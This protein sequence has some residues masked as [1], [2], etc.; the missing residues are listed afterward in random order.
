MGRNGPAR[1]A[2][3]PKKQNHRAGLMGRNGPARIALTPKKQ[4]GEH[5]GAML[6]VAC[7]RFRG[8]GDDPG[9]EL[10]RPQTDSLV[11]LSSSI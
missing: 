7:R 5:W 8:G 4:N 9:D 10:V 2:L 6:A 3:T 1:I 11:T